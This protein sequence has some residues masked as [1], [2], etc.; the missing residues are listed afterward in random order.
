MKS[1]LWF[2]WTLALGFDPDGAHGWWAKHAARCDACRSE[3]DRQ[4]EVVATLRESAQPAATPPGLHASIMS[5]VRKADRPSAVRAFPVRPVLAMAAA[6]VLA[7]G[8]WIGLR[9]RPGSAIRH[10]ALDHGGVATLSMVDRDVKH[11]TRRAADLAANP[12]GGEVERLKRDLNS[13]AKFLL[14]QL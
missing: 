3:L 8:L 9:S 6:A 1:C 5:R 14:A 7:V 13:A 10:P 12:F 2:R 4:R 11:L